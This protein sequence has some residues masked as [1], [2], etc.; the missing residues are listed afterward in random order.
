M[1][2]GRSIVGNEDIFLADTILAQIISNPATAK[3]A[4][5]GL[6]AGGETS[7]TWLFTLVQIGVVERYPRRAFFRLCPFP[8]VVVVCPAYPPLTA[9]LVKLFEL[10]GLE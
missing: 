3:T 7:D 1:G 9:T 10:P 8:P 4:V 5:K 2:D 6:A